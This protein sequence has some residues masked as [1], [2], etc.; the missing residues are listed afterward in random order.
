MATDIAAWQRKKCRHCGVKF[1]VEDPQRWA[2]K[3]VAKSGRTAYFCTW[4][5]LCTYRRAAEAKKTK[6]PEDADGLKEYARSLRAIRRYFGL[7]A[8]DLAEW[9][10]ISRYVYQRYDACEKTIPVKHLR[11]LTEG[12]GCSFADI[13]TEGFEIAAAEGWE[14]VIPS[15]RAGKSRSLK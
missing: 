1:T 9:L 15:C 13:I 10:G 8:A 2:Y 12:F 11:R 14:C 5:C 6:L 4:S 7:S 3:E